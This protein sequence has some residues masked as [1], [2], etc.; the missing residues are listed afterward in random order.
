MVPADMNVIRGHERVGRIGGLQRS[1][2]MVSE[3]Y[4]CVGR[5][6]LEVALYGLKRA[7]IAVDIRDDGKP[8]E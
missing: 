7:K 3:V 8:H 1:R 6:P 5:L 2:Q 4:D